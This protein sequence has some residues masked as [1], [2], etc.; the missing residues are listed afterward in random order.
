MVKLL[1][2]V[3]V[4][5]TIMSE[6]AVSLDLAGHTLGASGGCE[7]VIDA[8]E[9]MTISDSE[10]N[11]RVDGVV[12]MNAYLQPLTIKGG[13]YKEVYIS[14]GT[15]AVTGENINI[16]AL[17]L[18]YDNYIEG[19]LSSGT[20]GHIYFGC[21]CRKLLPNGEGKYYAFYDSDGKP[22]AVFDST[23]ELSNVTVKECNHSNDEA[24]QYT[25]VDENNHRKTC[26]ACGYSYEP[27]E[28]SKD[29]NGC[30][31]LCSEVCVELNGTTTYLD[32]LAKALTPEYSG[33]VLT[34]KRDVK[35]YDEITVSAGEFTLDIDGHNV[36]FYNTNTMLNLEGSAKLTIRDSKG[37]GKFINN[38]SDETDTFPSIQLYGSDNT[39]ELTLEGGSF[40]VICAYQGT[41][42]VT[43]GNVNIG[44][45]K[46]LEFRITD[47]ALKIQLSAGAY[48]KISKIYYDTKIYL[49]NLLLNYDSEGGTHY[50]FYNSDNELISAVPDSYQDAGREILAENVTVKECDHSNS[51]L[52]KYDRV[53]DEQHKAICSACGY[54]KLEDHTVGENGQCVCIAVKAELNDGSVNYYGSL[55]KALTAE[56]SG[57][58]ITLL[59][60][61]NEEVLLQFDSTA[62]STFTIDLNG[63]AINGFLHTESINLTMKDSVGNGLINSLECEGGSLTV[64]GGRFVDSKKYFYACTISEGC[65]AVINDGYFE[66]GSYGLTVYE[67]DATING[68]TFIATGDEVDSFFEP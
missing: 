60:D 21:G 42:N 26:L 19:A 34:L 65:Q 37:T 1:T 63:H 18:N 17:T 29:E 7:L 66:N 5:R 57:A 54:G 25:K 12:Q 36:D 23:P 10:E 45:L 33:A 44:E 61:I 43:G 3:Y 47:G 41:L 31:S 68:G 20:Y 59:K 50:A 55:E 49:N 14:K 58:V 30:C 40:D 56:N 48:G 8:Y 24:L 22:L 27:E 4:A 53:D 16:D 67:S 13:S 9:D 15:L 38:N 52:I 62:G 46:F 32:S 35:I 39:V 51:S 11:G 2:D 6:Y 28:H 64:D